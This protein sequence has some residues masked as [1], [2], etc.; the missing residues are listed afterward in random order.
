MDFIRVKGIHHNLV[1]FSHITP[2]FPSSLLSVALVP[3][4][5]CQSPVTARATSTLITS[6]AA[7]PVAVVVALGGQAGAENVGHG[8]QSGTHPPYVC[9]QL[10]T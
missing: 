10:S 5:P 1:F 7:L 3:L 4:P 8:L 2:S 9:P 6:P